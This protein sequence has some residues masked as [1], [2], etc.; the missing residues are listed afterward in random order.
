MTRLL[1]LSALPLTLAIL[2]ACSRAPRP[3]TEPEVRNVRVASADKA[4][5]YGD[6]DEARRR[7]AAQ[8][9]MTVDRVPEPLAMRPAPFQKVPASAWNRD[10]SATIKVEVVVDTLGRADM[11]TFRPV[12]V[13]NPWFTANIKSVIPRWRFT[14]ASLAGCKV[15][16]VYRFSATV[17]PRAKRR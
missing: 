10:G 8:P 1:S 3:E 4:L 17:P 16:R 15:R 7:L 11:S 14:P 2:S 9:D 6:C 12:Q 5:A 13:S